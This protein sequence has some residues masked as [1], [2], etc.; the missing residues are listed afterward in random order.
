MSEPKPFDKLMDE[1]FSP[2]QRQQI[3][4][5]A[6]KKIDSMSEP[7]RERWNTA[8]LTWLNGRACPICIMHEGAP[9]VLWAPEDAISIED[10]ISRFT[11]DRQIDIFEESGVDKGI[12][13]PMVL[14]CYSNECEHPDCHRCY[15]IQGCTI[16]DKCQEPGRFD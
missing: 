8:A 7:T 11:S 6:Q 10:A 13:T 4:A 5:A 12:H 1:R 14:W 15:P 3:E 2:E 16:H 9:V